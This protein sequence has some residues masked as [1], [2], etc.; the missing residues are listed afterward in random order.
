M[1]PNK[2]KVHVVG[3]KFLIDGGT[4]SLFLATLVLIPNRV[5]PFGEYLIYKLKQFI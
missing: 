2:T 4:I 5:S 1:L 3:H